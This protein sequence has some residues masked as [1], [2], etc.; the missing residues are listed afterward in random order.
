MPPKNRPKQVNQHR[1]LYRWAY[2]AA[3]AVLVLGIGFTVTT[4]RDDD[5]EPSIGRPW[6]PTSQQAAPISGTVP[7]S[8]ATFPEPKKVLTPEEI[9]SGKW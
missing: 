8:S 2:F 4:Q 1:Q 7:A 6:A 3:A 5:G 9:K